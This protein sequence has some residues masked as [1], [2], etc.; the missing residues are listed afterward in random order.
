MM[1]KLVFICSALLVF[2][3]TG[4]PASGEQTARFVLTTVD[5]RHMPVE[6]ILKKGPILI[7]FWASWCKS[8]KE[9]LQA[10]DTAFTDE[11]RNTSTIVAVTI[12]SP[13]SIL[14]ARSYIAARKMD[15]LFCTDPNSELLKQFSG[16]AIPYTVVID[17]NRNVLLRHPGY[18]PGDE[19][20]L[21]DQL[22]AASVSRASDT[23]PALNKR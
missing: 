3:F 10:L 7:T 8:C 9:E 18:A 2:I 14:H 16:K 11:V 15:F 1:H 5:G 22:R 19:K 6:D 17:T 4:I 20:H 21:L 13:R 23:P 12:D